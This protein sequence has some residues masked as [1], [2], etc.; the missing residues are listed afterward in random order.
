MKKQIV[1]SLMSIASLFIVGCGGDGDSGDTGSSA[2]GSA[3]KKVVSTPILPPAPSTFSR[4][5]SWELSKEGA[6]TYAL[7]TQG[8]ISDFRNTVY[9]NHPR[10]YFRDTDSSSLQAKRTSR[11]WN[12]FKAVLTDNRLPTTKSTTDSIAFLDIAEAGDAEYARML[13]FLAYLEKDTYY[14]NL[15]IAWAK[16][17][18]AMT[19]E[20]SAGDILLRRRIERLSEIYDWLHD[21]LTPA[22]KKIIRDGL[23]RQVNQLLRFDYMNTTR[24]YIQKHSRWGDAVVAQ[25]MLAMYGD[26]DADFTKAH[27]DSILSATREHL[28]NYQSVESYVASDG[29][30]HLGW[31]YAYFNA[32]YM[33]NY[34]IWSTATNETMLDDWMGGLTDWYMY[35]LRADKTLPQMGD[36]TISD[37]GYG[38]MAALYQSKFKK[39]GFAKWYVDE[40]NKDSYTDLFTR[41]ILSDDTV[42]AKNPSVLPTSRYFEKVGTVIARDTWDLDA[43]TLF[44]FKSSPFYN[45]GH[46]H[47]DENSFTIDYKSSLAIDSGFY[48]ATDTEHYKNYYVRTIAHNA[49]TVYNPNQIMEYITDYN[50]NDSAVSKR[51]INDGG[52]IYRNPDSLVKVDIV[53][54]GKNKIDGITKYQRNDN[55]T[56]ALGD[57]TKTYDPATV[58]LAKREVMYVQD[59]GFNHPVVLVLDK[60][61]GT[62]GD[63]Q[64]RYLLHS[65]PDTMPDIAGNKMT[66][67]SE[68]SKMVNL[69]IYPTNATLTSVG[70]S[71]KEYLLMDGTTNPEP[72]NS[73]IVREIKGEDTSDY[74]TKYGTWRLEVSPPLGSRY[75]VMLNA[76]FVDDAN[77]NINTSKVLL[78]DASN[79]VGIQLPN[80]VVVFSKDRNSA[81]AIEYKV[82]KDS[83][84]QHTVA[85]GYSAGEKVKVSVNGD[86][87]S[88]F[89]VGAGGCVDFKINV[90]TKDVIKVTK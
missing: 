59:A 40:N 72:I 88:G 14:V 54:G 36:A 87:T 82:A 27:A 35:G 47:R 20:N 76:L 57:A 34:F 26:F 13:A 22:D 67:V 32:N 4:Q 24:N 75:D 46:H 69:T 16:H 71:G 31:G 55:Y 41:F 61:E 11:D 6:P 53:E 56:Y 81:G 70:G 29:G 43:A 80:R 86:V 48:D 23:N 12:V 15:T 68:S 38:V 25:A 2:S 77:T 33:F 1:L 10:L 65:Q 44:I 7:S 9:P 78:I 85:T 42:T 84:I 19:P 5:N 45:A 8:T 37:M 89:I 74:V 64:K 39:D 62:S 50:V 18:A 3:P 63:Y 51:L 30:W 21:E 52:Q 49:I 90:T 83:N 17:L 60:I 79:S 73:A 66:V 58:S 28:R